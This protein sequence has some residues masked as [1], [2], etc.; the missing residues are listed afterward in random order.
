M[1]ERTWISYRDLTPEERD[2]FEQKA[3]THEPLWFAGKRWRV[4]KCEKGLEYFELRRNL[5]E[6]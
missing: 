1:T 2:R 6:E 5:A 4:A 3:E